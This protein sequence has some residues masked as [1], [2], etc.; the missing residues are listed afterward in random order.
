MYASRS[1]RVVGLGLA[2]IVPDMALFGRR[3]AFA[4][5]GAKLVAKLLQYP[6][7]GPLGTA[8]LVA[9]LGDVMTGDPAGDNVALNFGQS[10][11]DFINH[12]PQR[13][14]GRFIFREAL[15]PGALQGVGTGRDG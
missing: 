11:E 12:Q 3:L 8:G 13:S 1:S 10:A 7:N 14:Q 5:C 4:Q 9:Q 2:V 6:L 15:L